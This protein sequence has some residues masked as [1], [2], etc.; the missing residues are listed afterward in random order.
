MPATARQIEQL[1]TETAFAV[2]ALAASWQAQG[3]R[4]YPFHLGDI[5]LQPPP[6]MVA[7]VASALAAGKHGYTPGAGIPLLREQMARLVNDAFGS[8]YTA[9][10]VAVQPGGKPVIHK[11]LASVANPGDEVLYPVPGFPIYESQIR[12]L[13]GV[14]VPYF[15]Q[16]AKDGNFSLD[17]SSLQ[18]ALTPKTRALIL[19]NYHNPTGCM[20]DAA[21]L[22]AVADCARR[23]D[24]W[25]L[26]DEA[27]YAIRYPDAAGNTP[28]P[29]SIITR[30]G[31]AERA[32]VLLTCSKQFAMTG[33]RLGA[34][35]APPEITATIAKMNTNIESCT[36]HFIQQAVATALQE[37]AADIRPILAELTR[38]RDALTTALNNIGGIRVAAP[39]SGFYIYC[40][41]SE[42]LARHAMPRVDNL[43]RAALRASGV[44]FCTGEHFGE[45]NS[46]FIRFAFSGISVADINEGITHL[47]QFFDRA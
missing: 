41:V 45:T 47:K 26:S 11:F 8:H 32:V 40:D 6:A 16:H 39:P 18:N 25:V 3:N 5:N 37:D 13:G 27:Y 35:L 28:P 38:R 9:E 17:L 10:Q 22:D 4:I 2:S 29:D 19:N 36:A 23:H 33:W 46:H 12:Y 44:S 15:Y 1:G 30:A 21:T 20:V 7:G 42:I 43:M 24:L 31:I 34:A 14:P